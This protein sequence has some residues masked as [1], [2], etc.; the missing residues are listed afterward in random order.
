[1]NRRLFLKSLGAAG[2]S[3]FIPSSLNLMSMYKAANAA[4]D[5]AGASVVAPSIMPQ[6]INIFLYGG[7][8]EL[9][10]NLSNIVDINNN[11]QNPYETAFGGGIIRYQNDPAGG[12]ITPN[13]FWSTAGGN[14]MQFMLDQQHMSVYRTIMKRKDGTRSHRESI[15]MGLKG[16]LDIETSAGVGTRIAAILYQHRALFEGATTLADGTPIS[17]VEDLLLPF[18]SFEGETRA[19]ALDPDY[20]IPLLFRGLTL[21]QNFD[22][23]YSRG[24]NSNDAEINALVSKV[25][26]AAD[27]QRFAGVVNAF[28]L[29]EFLEARIGS[30]QTSSTAALPLVTEPQDY[31]SLDANATGPITLTYPNNRYSGKLRAAVTLAIENPS[32][33]FTTVGGDLGGWDDHNNGVDNY[34]TRMN[35]LFAALKAAMLHIKYAGTQTAGVTQTPGGMVRPTNNIVL[36]M[37]G[38]F[39]RLVN[40]NNSEGWDHGNNQNLYTFGGAAVRPAGALG[41]VVG[42]TVRSGDSGSNNQVTVPEAGSYEAEPMSI[43]ASVYSYFGVQNPQLLTSDP[44][45]NPNG[46]VALNETIAGEAKLF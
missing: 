20:S 4:V 45:L 7:P 17:N 28:E 18:V 44:V 31:L 16:S 27:Q 23:P 21:D 33:M 22:N 24:N 34:P 37:F 38:D 6:V 25:V 11:S 35:Q 36:N 8:S 26:T 15:L 3:V 42:R 5:Y 2:A 19:F 13:G 29:R 39:G 14:D 41:K 9:S 12:L 10:G 30:L 1:M 32:T 43:A 46:D 40:L